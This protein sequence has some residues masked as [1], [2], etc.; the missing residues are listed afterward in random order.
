MR[1]RDLHGP[2]QEITL[3]VDP[4][5]RLGTFDLLGLESV[6]LC[7]TTRLRRKLEEAFSGS[8][9]LPPT[10]LDGLWPG[11]ESRSGRLRAISVCR[12]ARPANVCAVIRRCGTGRVSGA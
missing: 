6:K 7:A 4:A 1:N 3:K 8:T 12:G 11:K 5:D 9:F 10:R 2:L